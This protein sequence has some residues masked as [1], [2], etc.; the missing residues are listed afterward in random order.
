[1]SGLLTN[2]R[3]RVGGESGMTLIELIVTALIGVIV[4][5]MLLYTWFSLQQSAAFSAASGQTRDDARNS[6][7]RMEMEIR[8]M[9]MPNPAPWDA[10]YTYP[11]L[12]RARPYWIAFFTT[13]NKPGIGTPGSTVAP[14]LVIYRL[15][16]DGKLYRFSGTPHV[17]DHT[18]YLT[19]VAEPDTGLNDTPPNYSLSEETNGQ[20]AMLIAT[21]VTNFVTSPA[22]PIFTYDYFDPSGTRQVADQVTGD[23]ACTNVMAVQI[24]LLVDQNPT[25]APAYVDFQTTAQLRNQR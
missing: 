7:A 8:D 20:G 24:H 3:R 4:G 1:M 5:T 17:V 12:Y 25:H 9:Q 11:A 18:A 16:G 21:N 14:Q 2:N 22:V 6:L 23:V 15:Y 19:G 10:T 13:F